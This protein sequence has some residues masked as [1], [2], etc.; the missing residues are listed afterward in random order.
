MTG[1]WPVGTTSRAARRTGVRCSSR[2]GVGRCRSPGFRRTLRLVS[3]EFELYALSEEHK[4]I[5]QAVR[6]VC[7]A[8]V[9]PHA[10]EV[11]ENAEFPKA[12]YDALKASDFH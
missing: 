6:D 4:A 2:R 8:K 11:D 7:D 12:S 10:G 9:A 1:P 5:R 3:S